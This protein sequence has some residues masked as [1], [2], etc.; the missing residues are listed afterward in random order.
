ME[1]TN[2]PSP[3]AFTIPT[4]SNFTVNLEWKIAF[5][6]ISTNFYKK[7]IPIFYKQPSY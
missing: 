2:D 3:D 1:D 5:K 6:L 4:F 7:N